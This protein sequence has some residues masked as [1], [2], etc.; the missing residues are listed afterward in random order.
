MEDR[1]E[2]VTHI[3]AEA[4]SGGALEG[5]LPGTKDAEASTM[6]TTLEVPPGEATLTTN[7]TGRMTGGQIVEKIV[8]EIEGN[9]LPEATGATETEKNGAKGGQGMTMNSTG[10]PSERADTQSSLTTTL[11][12]I[13]ST[14]QIKPT[15]LRTTAGGK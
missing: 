15:E 4:S 5:A 14:T 10:G 2:K 6:M 13:R 11:V 1:K 7:L 9:L 8:S 3:A 12:S